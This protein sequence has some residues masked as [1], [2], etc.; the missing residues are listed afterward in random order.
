MLLTISPVGFLNAAIIRNVL[1][2]RVYATESQ[3]L[4]FQVL[5]LDRVVAVLPN[6]ALCLG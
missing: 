1:S 6:D 5:H 2:L 4:F 3:F